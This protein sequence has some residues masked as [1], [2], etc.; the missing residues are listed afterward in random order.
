MIHGDTLLKLQFLFFFFIG[1]CAGST[2]GAIKIIRTILVFKFLS[3]ELKKLIHPKGVFHIKIS[4]KRVPEE[5]V[6]NTVGFYLFYIFIFVFAGILF[7]FLGL[8]FITS[9]SASASAIGNIGPGL[10]GIGPSENWDI[11]GNA[12]KVLASSLMLLGRLEIFTVMLL[13]SGGFTKK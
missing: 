2:T 5:I 6:S 7:S 8:D 10:G 3:R 11:V 12:G 4:D 9:L 13:F 1:G